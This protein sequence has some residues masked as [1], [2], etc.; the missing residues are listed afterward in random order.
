MD[1]CNAS[2]RDYDDMYRSAGRDYCIMEQ[3]RIAKRKYKALEQLAIAI[4]KSN[5]LKEHELK[6]GEQTQEQAGKQPKIFR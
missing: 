4:E 5:I 2:S 3:A 1:N 6:L